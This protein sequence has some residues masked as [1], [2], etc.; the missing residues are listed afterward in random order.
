MIHV[1]TPLHRYP[2]FR[3]NIKPLLKNQDFLT[4]S[5]IFNR[6]LHQ[7]H[8]KNACLLGIP[9]GY[10]KLLAHGTAVGFFSVI[11]SDLSSVAGFYEALAK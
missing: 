9:Q 8:E 1:L 10:N 6:K 3:Y 2:D 5:H 4:L 7:L 11:P